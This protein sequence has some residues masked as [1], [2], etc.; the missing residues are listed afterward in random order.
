MKKHNQSSYRPKS[1]DTSSL[2]RAARSKIQSTVRRSVGG[3]SRLRSRSKS[4][5]PIKEEKIQKNK[6]YQT[7]NTHLN[8]KDVR[9]KMREQTKGND[10][11]IFSFCQDEEGANKI[12]T[13]LRET[14]V[15]K[16]DPKY[17]TSE[18]QTELPKSSFSKK[19]IPE[20]EEVIGK[21]DDP[22]K[23]NSVDNHSEEKDPEIKQ[24]VAPPR[25]LIPEEKP[26]K[27]RDRKRTKKEQIAAALKNTHYR[28]TGYS[29]K[30]NMERIILILAQK[31]MLSYHDR[32][33]IEKEHEKLKL[34]IQKRNYEYKL[35]QL[36][37]SFEESEGN[38][39]SLWESRLAKN[40]VTKF[41]TRVDFK[42]VDSKLK[43]IRNILNEK[44]FSMEIVDKTRIDK[45]KLQ[46][47]VEKNRNF[48]REFQD[49][50]K[51]A[52]LKVIDISK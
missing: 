9:S 29:L 21:I 33:R 28:H 45:N 18:R 4:K 16:R 11:L 41:T 42:Y 34:Q 49:K 51:R 40:Q 50:F 36:K 3:E 6:D 39:Q 35:E 44:E 12:E 37:G 30:R 1:K 38:V 46:E 25:E 22:D 10:N 14:E 15:R 19:P 43:K 24:N 23:K 48:F 32:I 26:R 31:Y 27:K 47:K 7:E 2:K 8:L 5:S 13:E 20:T 52:R 17:V